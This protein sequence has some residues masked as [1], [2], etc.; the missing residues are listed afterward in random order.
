M[1][2]NSNVC[3]STF[4]KQKQIHYS[5]CLHFIDA[6]M[7]S[8]K[9]IPGLRLKPPTIGGLNIGLFKPGLKLNHI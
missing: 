4:S 5:V 7:F 3:T 1:F 6:A 2:V 8:I 9:L